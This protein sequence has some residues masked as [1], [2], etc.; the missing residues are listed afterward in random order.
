[1]CG[2]NSLAAKPEIEALQHLIGGDELVAAD[3]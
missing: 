2:R 1:V 3:Q